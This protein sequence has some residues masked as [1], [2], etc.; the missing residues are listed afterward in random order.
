MENEHIIVNSNRRDYCSFAIVGMADWSGLRHQRQGQ[1]APDLDLALR[2][3]PGPNGT[4]IK[5][6]D[7]LSMTSLPTIMMQ[8]QPKNMT[9]MAEAGV[10]LQLSGHTHGGQLWPQHI[11]LLDYDAISGLHAF[12]DEGNPSYLFVSEGI[13]GWGPRLRFLS[14]TDFAILTLRNSEIMKREGLLADTHLTV[15]TFAMYSAVMLVPVSLLACLVPL[16]CRTK[17]RCQKYF[18]RGDQQG[19]RTTTSTLHPDAE[20]A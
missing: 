8:H 6:T 15:A 13:V 17:S 10:G 12:G 1:V 7:R 16:C 3:T 2:S 18:R 4:T 5:T 19:I 14:K 20:L 11:F 9:E